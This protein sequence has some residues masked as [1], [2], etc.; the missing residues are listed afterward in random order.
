MSSIQIFRLQFCYNKIFHYLNKNKKSR[1]Y[2]LQ[3][4]IEKQYLIGI[5]SVKSVT[6]SDGDDL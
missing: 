1:Q 3:R 5:R 6:S 4:T 2:K